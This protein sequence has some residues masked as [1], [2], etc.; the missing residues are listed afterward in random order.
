MRINRV[1][2]SRLPIFFCCRLL[3]FICFTNSISAEVWIA[4]ESWN[5]QWENRYSDWLEIEVRPDFLR[6]TG[7]R[8]DCADLVYAFRA[9]FARTHGL[10]FMASSAEGKRYGHFSHHWDR[11]PTHENWKQDR[12]FCTFLNDLFKNIVSTRSLHHDTYPVA[13]NPESICPGLLVYEDLI[14]AHVAMVGQ[15]RSD[16]NLPVTFYESFIPGFEEFTVS[17]KTEVHL[18]GPTIAQTHSGIVAWKWPV[19]SAGEWRYVPET[20]MPHFSEEQYADDFSYRSRTTALLNRLAW[21]KLHGK[22]FIEDQIVE[23]YVRYLIVYFADRAL[24]I[25]RAEQLMAKH[26]DHSLPDYFDAQCATQ[27]TDAWITRLLEKTWFSLHGFDIPR[28]SFLQKLNGH[29]ILISSYYPYVSLDVLLEAF[30]GGKCSGDLRRPFY[31]RWGIL[32]EEEK[33]PVMITSAGSFTTHL[34]EGERKSR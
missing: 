10:P 32:V 19:E 14:A 13:L 3:V 12:R 15:I 34:A 9:V 2:S 25:L 4:R 5:P 22:P 26:G 18:Y 27:N 17:G 21:E 30:D 28:A 16:T 20:E 11:F 7:L 8:V 33:K 23:E 1:F 29:T 31:H 24:R 6:P